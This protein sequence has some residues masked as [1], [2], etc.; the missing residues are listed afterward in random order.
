MSPTTPLSCARFWGFLL[1]AS[2]AAAQ[3]P[4]P[5]K[6]GGHDLKQIC[7]LRDVEATT[8]IEDAGAGD[9]TP[10]ETLARASFLRFEARAACGRG[11]W[12]RGLQFYDKALM[13]LRASILLPGRNIRTGGGT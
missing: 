2:V 3:S 4:A 8:R 10:A 9:A 6:V 5:Q 12:R 11:E 7:L 1:T 13:E